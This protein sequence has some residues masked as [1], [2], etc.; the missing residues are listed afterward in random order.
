MVDVDTRE[1][2]R[3]FP[4]LA[5]ELESQKGTFGITSVNGVAAV[6]KPVGDPFSGYTPT[7]L[8][9]LRRCGS[10]KE[11]EETIDYLEKK[12]E[13]D[14]EYAKQL[15][16]TLKEHGLSSFGPKKEDDYYLKRAGYG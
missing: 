1:F 15:R 12:G 16:K 14:S 9:Y 11:A 2:K 4:H 3:R 6:E 7:V 13:I 10:D 5:K 8:D